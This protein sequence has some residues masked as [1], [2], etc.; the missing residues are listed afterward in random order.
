MLD[1]F[2]L[3]HVLVER[4]MQHSVPP[5]SSHTTSE[6]ARPA[7]DIGANADST[8]APCGTSL[9]SDSQ[10]PPAIS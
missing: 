6:E 1:D 3:Q 9:S 10:R 7:N 2:L 8:V 4:V 5:D